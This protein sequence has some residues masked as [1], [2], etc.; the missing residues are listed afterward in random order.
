LLQARPA[1]LDESFDADSERMVKAWSS[2][3][4]NHIDRR[5]S[6]DDDND[7]ERRMDSDGEADPKTAKRMVC[8]LLANN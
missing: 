1:D 7:D 4:D 8:H 2:K 3:S 5:H 6:D